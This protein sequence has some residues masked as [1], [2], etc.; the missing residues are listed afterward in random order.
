MSRGAKIS[1]FVVIAV[2]VV[3]GLVMLGKARGG[4]G[5]TEVRL[6]QVGRRDLVAAVTASGQIEAKTQVDISSEVT[7]RILK[8]H[9]KEGDMVTPGELLVELDQAQFKGAVERG[10]AGIAQANAS[11]VQAT[12]NRDQAKR[13]LD[14]QR[15]LKKSQPN[16]V[17][18]ESVE[19]A[20]Q[21]YL[22]ADANLKASNAQLE[23]A[24]ATLKEAQDNLA[25]TMLYSPIA[26]RV[27]R[28][29]VQEGEV[30]VPGSFSKDVGLLMSIA[31]L[32]DIIAK[33]KVDET[34]VVRLALGDSVSVSI[35]AFPD[36][37]FAGRVTK[38]GNSAI[39]TAATGT[40]KAVDF[41][42]EVTLTDPPKDVR[43]DLSMTGRIITS[44]RKNVLSI[45]IIALTARAAPNQGGDSS[46][47]APIIR[48][49]GDTTKPKVKEQDG[50]FVV[51]N[52]L[53][54]FRPVK[55]GIT[56]DEYFEVLD[57]LKQGETIVAGTYQA[58]RDMKDSTRV[59]PMAQPAGVKKP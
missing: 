24:Q 13:T 31:D 34:D 9:V 46:A 29:A 38:R 25:R 3:G 41:E 7:A 21:Q 8:I 37:T 48:A 27:V 14:R 58:I 32:S 2:V 1:L 40:D 22:V 47:S 33:V 53:A 51:T 52:G 39:V 36:T 10:Q 17:T 18:D 57:G 59:K 49:P 35:D 43:P 44:V 30:A 12:A 19:L 45:P 50:V 16:L 6:E 23:Q 11:V 42:V 4:N 28:L 26:G 5:A 54:R 15:E 56:G 20:N 55:V